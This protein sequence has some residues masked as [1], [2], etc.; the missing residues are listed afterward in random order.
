[1]TRTPSSRALL[2]TGLACTVL[3]GC[4][5]LSQFLKTAFREPTFAF[6]QLGL[7]DIN[8]GGLTLDTVWQLDNPNN[9]SLS[10]ASVEYSLLV[11]DKQVVA[12]A[13]PQGFT[14]AA[15]GSTD[16][17][18]P[19]GIKFQDLVQVVETFLTKD[20]ATYK[21]SGA[22]GIQTPVG[23]LRLPLSKSGEFEVPKI[24]AVVF[25]DPRVSNLSLT[26]ATIEFPLTVTNKNS[27]PLP[28]GVLSGALTVA[29]ASVG[30]IS[31]G[32]LGLMTEKGTKQV[33]LPVNVSFLSA[34]MAVFNAINSGKAPVQFNAQLQSGAT[35][36]PLKV[37]QL[38]NFIR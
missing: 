31:T 28:L 35:T 19:A 27:F 13:P 7:T 14:M 10:L 20:S 32:E 30:S 18:F 1:M 11:D 23:V 6:K 2:A 21:A 29:G 5:Y 34:A 37:D 16:L 24:P 36:V 33:A 9:V 8:L 3:S 25:G 12:G 17:H 15:Q 4:A 38:V 26:G 22:L